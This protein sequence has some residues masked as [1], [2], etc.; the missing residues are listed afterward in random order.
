MSPSTLPLTWR[1]RTFRYCGTNHR[2][3]ETYGVSV[4]KKPGLKQEKPTTT[5]GFKRLWPPCVLAEA[6]YL[7][8]KAL[9]SRLPPCGG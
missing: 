2:Y 8:K 5:G 4:Q 9:G 3:D 1:Q 7:L 6:W